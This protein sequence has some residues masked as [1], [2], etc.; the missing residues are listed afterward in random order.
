M[1]SQP[2]SEE[3]GIILSF[4]SDSPTEPTLYALL[5]PLAL[6]ENPLPAVMVQPRPAVWLSLSHCAFATAPPLLA[7]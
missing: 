2:L 7:S 4:K 5:R 6:G 1:G 3:I